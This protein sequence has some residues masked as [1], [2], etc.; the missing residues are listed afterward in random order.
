M[1][2]PSRSGQ[3][4]HADADRRWLL[5][6]LGIA[7]MVMLLLDRPL[8]RGD[9]VAYLA[10]VDSFVLDADIQFD[11]QLERLRNVNTYQLQWNETTQRLVNIFP[12]GAAIIETPFYAIGHWFAV[13]GWWDANPD[14][15]HA[16]QGV[17]RPYSLW[18]MIGANVMGLV[19]V[20]VSWQLAR[21]FTSAPNATLVA[22]ATLLG[23]PL[24]YYL[25]VSPL[26]SHNAGAFAFALFLW[27]LLRIQ[28]ALIDHG[29]GKDASSTLHSPLFT[30]HFLLLGLTAGLM[31]LSRWQ[32][33][34]VAAPAWPIFF[35]PKT[36]TWHALKHP[37]IATLAAAIVCLPLPISWNI[38][39]GEPF[40]IPYDAVN[41]SNGTFLTLP[42]N[43]IQVLVQ[44]IAHSP[45]IALAL[46]GVV[47]LWR[48]QRQ[49]AVYAAVVIGLQLYLNGGV[50][51]WWAGETYGM[52]R[53]SELFPLYALLIAALLQSV[54]RFRVTDY[55]LRITLFTVTLY[56]LLY[57]LI[58]VN[59]TWTNTDAVF[60]NHVPI[61]WEHFWSQPNRWAV[62]W[63]VWR[64]HLGPWA[65]AMP[66]P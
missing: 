66:G 24:L 51:D 41:D 39:F 53:M 45:V 3:S 63:E 28:D 2:T 8:V 36:L 37:L 14:Y 59:Y 22:L 26:N 57:L 18:L 47:A 5:L 35:R 27:L 13:N 34:L 43:A 50:L 55:G 4:T 52:R 12:F 19:V 44:T 49:L 56:A 31:V 30:L 48:P 21:R 58:F 60:I 7:L 6:T 64:T 46:A 42:R 65:W 29:A 23:T 62:T 25:T 17:W 10:W 16:Q 11:N 15:F 54:T 61:M 38:M 40:V 20:G 9:G 33:L 32:L 1:S